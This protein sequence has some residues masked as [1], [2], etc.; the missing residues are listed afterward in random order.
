MRVVPEEVMAEWSFVGEVEEEWTPEPEAAREELHGDWVIAPRTPWMSF[1]EGDGEPM[2]S[3]AE[4][5][6]VSD[7]EVSDDEVSDDTLPALIPYVEVS[8]DEPADAAPMPDGAGRL[9]RRLPRAESE[10]S[11]RSSMPP[12]G[13]AWQLAATVHRYEWK[14]GGTPLGVP[15][16]VHPC[17]PCM[18][19]AEA[20]NAAEV[21]TKAEGQKEREEQWLDDVW[22]YEAEKAARGEC[23]WCPRPGTEGQCDGCGQLVCWSCSNRSSVYTAATAVAV[24]HSCAMERGVSGGDLRALVESSPWPWYMRK[25]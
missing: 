14:C 10:P 3:D 8:D 1:H 16:P 17:M 22:R 15:A 12:F 25:Y 7:D 5:V 24:C 2:E 18:H 4:H 21:A 9:R 23:F 13:H 19:S 20:A 11:S 6:E